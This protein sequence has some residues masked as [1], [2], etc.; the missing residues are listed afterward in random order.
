MQHDVLDLTARLERT[1]LEC[2]E[3][4]TEWVA[5]VAGPCP[6]CG[7]R[8]VERQPDEPERRQLVTA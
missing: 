7:S 1:N 6:H 4:G 2:R 8:N 3:C 5:R